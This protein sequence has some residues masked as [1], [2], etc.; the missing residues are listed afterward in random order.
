MD[1]IYGKITDTGIVQEGVLTEFSLDYDVAGKKDFELTVSSETANKNFDFWFAQGEEYGGIIERKRI[2]SGSGE[3]TYSGRNTRGILDSRVIYT[4]S[5]PTVELEGN[6]EEIFQTYIDRWLPE[7]FTVDDTDV[8]IPYQNLSSGTTLY[9][10][11]MTA[12]RHF[13]LHLSFKYDAYGKAHIIL[14]TVH[15]YSDEITYTGSNTHSFI[16]ETGG[17]DCTTLIA[18]CDL[19]GKNHTIYL[20]TDEN[21]G[22]QP[23]ATTDIPKSDLD[24]LIDDDTYKVV[25]GYKEKVKAEEFNCQPKYNFELLHEVPK[26]WSVL[27]DTYY[28]YDAEKDEY[29]EVEGVAGEK[30]S[31]LSSQPDDWETSYDSYY[32]KNS[33]GE[34]QAAKGTSKSSYTL[35]T[36]KPK[37]WAVNFSNYYR[38]KTDGTT[39]SYYSVP[40]ATSTVYGK[41]TTRP[42]KW[43]SSF[44]SYY[45]AAKSGNKWT[46]TQVKGV[47]KAKSSPAWIKGKYYTKA[48]VK[49]TPKFKLGEIYYQSKTVDVAPAFIA[50]TY[51]KRTETISAPTWD[52]ASYYKRY[53]DNYASLVSQAL[54][55]LKNY[56]TAQSVT[57]TLYKPESEVGDIVGCTDIETNTSVVGTVTNII[58]KVSGANEEYQ[59]EVGD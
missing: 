51:S 18:Y 14:E 55:S 17:T 6:F 2:D 4:A 30:Y 11:M 3:I 12:C 9:E 49:S 39:Y 26:W 24:Y 20:Y 33:E 1:L 37:D 46:Y 25:T 5:A 7:L 29:A 47:G 43:E 16:L 48:T 13:N 42:S 40:S 35:L 28:T 19:N 53:T 41:Q 15:D 45:Q 50:N 57:F 44:G 59:Y 34:Y 27:F 32:T 8:E 54:E 52:S 31:L 38:R 23:Y 36:S 10:A 21:G 58:Y 22:V 56:I